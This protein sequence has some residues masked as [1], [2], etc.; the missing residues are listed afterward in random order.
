MKLRDPA[1]TGCGLHTGAKTVCLLDEQRLGPHPVMVI[2]EAP[3]ATE[4]R[5]GTPFAGDA[6]RKLRD[7]LGQAGLSPQSCYL[8]NAVKCRPPKNRAPRL[9]EIR[10]C[11]SFLRAELQEVRPAYLVLLGNT[12]LQA[13]LGRKGITNERGR[14]VCWEGKQVLPTFH[15]AAVLRQPD[16]LAVVRGDLKTV[17]DLLYSSARQALLE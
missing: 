16:R 13:V 14:L 9:G 4:D 11:A 12:A 2:G 17:S 8:T 1:C 6:G 10:A 15:P 3:G 7:L 5:E